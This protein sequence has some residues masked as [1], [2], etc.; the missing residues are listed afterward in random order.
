MESFNLAWLKKTKFQASIWSTIYKNLHFMQVTFVTHKQCNTIN[1]LYSNIL[2]SYICELCHLFGLFSSN[3]VKLKIP[4]YGS[5]LLKFISKI[6]PPILLSKFKV[7]D[8]IAQVKGQMANI[9]HFYPPFTKIS[10]TKTVYLFASVMY[11]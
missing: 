9:R 6:S 7:V 4:R 10:P 5:R 3:P 11:L 1:Y 8:R 2:Q